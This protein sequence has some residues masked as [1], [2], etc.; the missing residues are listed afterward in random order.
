MLS[1]DVHH[2]NA[3]DILPTLKAGSVRA[4]LTS[5]PFWRKRRYPVPDTVWP[6]GTFRMMP[7]A[8]PQYIKKWTGQLGWEPDVNA[9]IAHLVMVFRE[10]RRV[11]RR[12]GVLWVNMG[13]SMS[14]NAGGNGTGMNSARKG[15]TF[16]QRVPTK[17]VEG[18]PLKSL[19]GVPA[20]L[21]FALQA[22]GWRWR[23]RVIWHKPNPTPESVTD[24]CVE[25]T[26]DFLF[27]SKARHYYWNA[28]AMQEPIDPVNMARYER[29]VKN[30][31]KYDPAKHK[32]GTNGGRAP[33]EILT[34]AAKRIVEKGTRTRRNVW[35]IPTAQF[36]G[37]H[38]AVFPAE[39]IEPPLLA[40]TK[41]GD[42]IIDPFGGSGTTAALA[43]HHGRSADTIEFADDYLP[44]IEERLRVI[45]P[46]FPIT[47][48]QA[49]APGPVVEL[50]PQSVRPARRRGPS[51][52]DPVIL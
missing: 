22:D 15:R 39:L 11:L 49:S 18:V 52:E 5:P 45:E 14:T 40:S 8:P 24:R 33:M 4:C 51:F 7:G 44:M 6:G 25:C 27:F 10:V 20:R 17:K 9:F 43:L 3:L 35:T 30:G 34:A 29:A 47:I 16:T 41:P 36:D 19:I 46:V 28:D 13:D 12:D 31:E 32:P 23:Q 48:E 50:P 38:F 1:A 21:A 37:K 2:G 42:R 26:E